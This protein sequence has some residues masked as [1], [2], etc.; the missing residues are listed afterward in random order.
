MLTDCV[1]RVHDPD[2]MRTSR[3]L[4]RQLVAAVVHLCSMRRELCV[5]RHVA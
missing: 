4:G 2:T 5:V 3:Q 1:V